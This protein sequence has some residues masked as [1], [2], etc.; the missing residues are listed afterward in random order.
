MISTTKAE[1]SV[2]ESHYLSEIDQMVPSRLF[3][4]SPFQI[5]LFDSKLYK[6]INIYVHRITWYPL[7]GKKY[8]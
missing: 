5:Q 3:S 8:T 1:N 2:E 4:V 6:Q 7:E